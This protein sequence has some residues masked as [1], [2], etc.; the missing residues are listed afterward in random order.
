MGFVFLVVEGGIMVRT[1]FGL[2]KLQ[3]F[4]CKGHLLVFAKLANG[5]EICF[6]PVSMGDV[7]GSRDPLQIMSSLISE[8]LGLE[9]G[10]S[11][12]L[13]FFFLVFDWDHVVIETKRF[14][15]PC[16]S[17]LEHGQVCSMVD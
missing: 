5:F 9:L 13:Y 16:A 10:H 6:G 17:N 2:L 15:L 14:I 12:L 11:E 8:A 7:L 3:H 4:L 1:S